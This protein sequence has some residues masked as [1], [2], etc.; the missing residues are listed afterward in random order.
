MKTF[1]RWPGNKSKYIKQLE[2]YFPSV[3]GTYI[4]PFVGSGAVLLSLQPKKWIIG[5]ANRDL[6]NLWRVVKDNPEYIKSKILEFQTIFS[7]LSRDDKLR[8]CKQI[9]ENIP[10]MKYNNERA[11]VYLLMTFCAFLGL[12]FRYNKFVFNSLE[13]KVYMGRKNL[14]FASDKYLGNLGDV[15]KYLN[16]SK[17][18]IYHRDYKHIL[19]MSK[20]GDFVF[21]DPPYVE[22]RNYQFNYNKN[23]H[24]EESMLH[25]LYHEVQNLDRKG[26]KW[27]MTQADTD[28]VKQVFGKKYNIISFR[29]YRLAAKTY[30]K[31]LIIRNYS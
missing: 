27:M 24:L 26:V 5:D 29:V 22:A 31:E 7:E 20:Q 6:V 23:E 13:P 9:T 4:E 19:A 11:V 10:S 18:K 30:R 21:L 25:E 12:I 2:P 3:Y 17:G 28:Q 8:L 15:S 1:I 14:Y 16:D